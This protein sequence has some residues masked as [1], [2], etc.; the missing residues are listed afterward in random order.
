MSKVSRT[1]VPDSIFPETC[2]G[3][4]NGQFSIEVSGGSMPYSVSLDDIDG[5]TVAGIFLHPLSRR[6]IVLSFVI[7]LS[8]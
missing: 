5:A 8:D 6:P 3:D 2:S 1:I 4:M 7:K